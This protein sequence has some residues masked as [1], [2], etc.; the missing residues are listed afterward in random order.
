MCSDK[1]RMKYVSSLG[2]IFESYR[3][4]IYSNGFSNFEK[5]SLKKVKNL[6]SIICEQLNE[7]IQKNRSEDGLFEAYN[8]ISIDTQNQSIDIENLDLMLEVKRL[9]STAADSL[10]EK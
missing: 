3:E 10:K 4:K 2:K 8:T 5:L 9:K 7:S 1:D 6:I